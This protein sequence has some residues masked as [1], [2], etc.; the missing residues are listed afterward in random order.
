M[1]SHVIFGDS[2][3][4][5]NFY[6]LFPEI[7]NILDCVNEWELEIKSWLKLPI[8]LF[9]PMEEKRILFGHDDSEA[10]VLPV[11]FTNSLGVVL[12]TLAVVT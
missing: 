3:L 6:G 8:E 9:K 2:N 11:V 1:Q 7:M 12:L 5:G 4:G 10:K